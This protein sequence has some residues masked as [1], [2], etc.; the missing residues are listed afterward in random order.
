MG[1]LSEPK[2]VARHR[3]LRGR[4][5]CIDN[6]VAPMVAS[7]S[8][9]SSARSAASGTDYEEVFK[10]SSS[11]FII[12]IIEEQKLPGES[13]HL[14]DNG[15][16]FWKLH[17]N[18]KKVKKNEV[19]TVCSVAYNMNYCSNFASLNLL[20]MHMKLVQI[21]SDVCKRGSVSW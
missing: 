18:R 3:T 19:G 11:E 15:E 6:R 20:P 7:L 14:P 12:P 9:N 4:L 21:F 8:G 2:E 1:Q 13:S 16:I 17:V 5:L 10:S